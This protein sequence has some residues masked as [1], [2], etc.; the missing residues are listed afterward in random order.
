[1]T[2]SPTN[3]AVY[4]YYPLITRLCSD[5]QKQLGR[6]IHYLEIG[7]QEGGSAAAAFDSGCIDLAVLI[8]MWGLEYGGTGRGGPDHICNRLGPLM[9]K[10]LIITGSSHAVVPALRHQFDL[11]FVDGDHSAEGC[12]MDMENCLPLLESTG[13]MLA[14]D[15]DHPQHSYI[16]K[17]TGDFAKLHHLSIAYHNLCYGVAELRKQP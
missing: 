14:D 10:T 6:G 8:D 13:V 16:R 15:T 17:V 7:T 2:Q 1:M 5:Q 4:E 3:Y 11:I 12:R 9:K